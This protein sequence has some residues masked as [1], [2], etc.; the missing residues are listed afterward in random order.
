MNDPQTASELMMQSQI[1]KPAEFVL[2]S[3]SVQKFLVELIEQ[4]N[5]P[6]R[7]SEF[8]SGVKYHLA[9]AEIRSGE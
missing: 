3:T 2:P 8:V 5:F 9:N 1:K 6:G 7:M 4:S